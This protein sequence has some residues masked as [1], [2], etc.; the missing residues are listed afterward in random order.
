MLVCVV[1]RVEAFIAGWG[2]GEALRRGEAYR[3][4]GADGV[5]GSQNNAID[6]AAGDD[7]TDDTYVS[8]V[9]S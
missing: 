7:F 8:K 1:A 2:L 6:C 5:L 9:C 4:A 3:Q